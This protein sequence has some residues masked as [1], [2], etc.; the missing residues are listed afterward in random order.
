MNIELTGVKIG[1]IKKGRDLG[2]R[3]EGKYIWIACREY[4]RERWT[5]L[6]NGVPLFTRCQSC[7]HLVN[8]GA[9]HPGWKGG[10]LKTCGGYIEVKIY[11]DNFF[12]PM[13]TKHGYV[14]EHRLVMAKHLGRCLLS[15][16]VIHHRNGIKDD[17][18]LENL[19][20]LGNKGKHN[21]LIQQE[22]KR[23]TK[24]VKTLQERVTL[25]E[26]ENLILQRQL[27]GAF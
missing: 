11:P 19:E 10:R 16:E 4:G 7:Y 14:M 5:V 15:W 8:K 20:L 18:R 12:Y 17:N 27:V 6:R 22:L 3:Y 9:N 23:L 24:E 26:A 1:E 21:T 13:A 2:L 25:L